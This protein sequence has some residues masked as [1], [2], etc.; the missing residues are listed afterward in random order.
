MD[1][2]NTSRDEKRQ[3]VI[4]VLKSVF[5]LVGTLKSEVL[6]LNEAGVNLSKI[7]KACGNGTVGGKM[8]KVQGNGSQGEQVN[9]IND[10]GL[11]RVN[12]K[13]PG[14]FYC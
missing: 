2:D 9:S 5:I 8:P 13:A 12:A 7:R 1:W 14:G 10:E 11:V 3:I 6:E 4:Q